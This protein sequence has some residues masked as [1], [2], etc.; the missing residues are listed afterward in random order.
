MDDGAFQSLS[1]KVKLQMDDAPDWRIYERVA[2]SFEVENASM[3][4]SVTPNALLLGSVS[5]IR[6]QIDILV[7]ARFESGTER[8]I[9]YDAKRRRRK[10]NVQDVDGFVGLMADVRA[11]RGVLVCTNGWSKAAQRRADEVIELR[12]ITEEEAKEFDHAAIDLCPNCQAHNRKTKG[13]VFW[14]G[15]FPLPLG[16]CAIVLLESVMCVAAS[17]SGVGSAER[18]WSFPTIPNTSADVDACGSLRMKKTIL[19]SLSGQR[20]VKFR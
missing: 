12:L 18:S 19:C 16:G 14:D 1:A 2:A 15:Q 17:R 3:D 13:V 4:V 8:R 5:M 11:A 7:D 6:R 20:Q 10:L 9:I